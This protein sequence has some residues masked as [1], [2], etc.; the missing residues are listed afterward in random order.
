MG[1]SQKLREFGKAYED[2]QNLRKKYFNLNR[3]LIFGDYGRACEEVETAR[4]FVVARAAHVI[5]CNGV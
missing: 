2:F 5:D 4:S 3:G 1:S